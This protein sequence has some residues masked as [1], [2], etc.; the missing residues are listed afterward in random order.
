MSD[1]HKPRKPNDEILEYIKANFEYGSETGIITNGVY[2][3]GGLCNGY[4]Q[5]GFTIN[6]VKY[7]NYGHHIAWFL[8]YGEWPDNTIDHDDRIRT[9]NKINNLIKTTMKGQSANRPDRSKNLTYYNQS[10]Y[11]K[12]IYRRKG[13][14][15]VYIIRNKKRYYLGVHKEKELA[16]KA[17]EIFNE[18]N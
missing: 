5:I 3:V 10:K 11:G 6:K 16:K 17:I 7:R 9:N 1:Y 2:K 18:R 13:R 12:S 15:E 8:Y 4:T 14:F